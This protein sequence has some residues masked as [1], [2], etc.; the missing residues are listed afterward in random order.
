[1]DA[2]EPIGA[3]KNRIKL[4]PGHYLDDPPLDQQ[5]LHVERMRATQEKIGP[6]SYFC[7]TSASLL[8]GLPLWFADLDLVDVVRTGGGHGALGPWVRFFTT[9]KKTPQIVEVDG[10][11]VTSL[12]RTAAD[13]MRHLRFG[14][15]LALADAVLRL[16][17]SRDQL[18]REVEKGRGCRHST[19]AAERADPRS[20]SP[21]ESWARAIML[22]NSLPMPLLQR[23]FFDAAGF[24]GRVDFYWPQ[25]RLVGEFDGW[26]KYD[27][28]LRPGQTKEDVLLAQ[29][30]RQARIEALGE[31][32]I[33]FDKDDVH[34]SFHLA[35]RLGRALGD[36]QVDHGLCPEALDLRRSRRSR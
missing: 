15:S 28:L 21:Y 35:G 8:H 9:P 17:G 36:R 32:F 27:R 7:R 29:G 34:D 5:L 18:L 24:I 1:M 10:L 25:F 13:V 3:P 19:E 20:E 33:R 16:G 4:R 22:Q 12:E 6:A 26:V 30:I 11:R 2:H 14:P 23:E 31:R